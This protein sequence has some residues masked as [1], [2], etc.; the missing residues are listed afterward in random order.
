M[1]QLMTLQ[2]VADYL[3]VTRKTVYR[4]LEGGKIPAAKVGR[5]WRFDRAAID[6]WLSEKSVSLKASIL[7]IDDEEIIRALLEE[8]VTDL[9]HRV[10]S[11]GTSSEGLELVTQQDFDL[12]FLDLKMPDMDGAELFRRIK[13]IK[14]KLPVIIITGYPD[15]D[16]MARALVHGPFAVM[17][18]PFSESDIIVAVNG[19]LHVTQVTK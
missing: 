17:N 1:T 18:K 3:R 8:T 12:V 10:V 4:L 16:M 19:F 6:K 11:A 7:V 5:Q 14:P 13:I 2:E 9:G 15:S